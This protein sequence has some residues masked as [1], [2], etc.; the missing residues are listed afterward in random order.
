MG[1][2]VDA[3]KPSACSVAH[4]VN[5]RAGGPG[6]WAA[7]WAVSFL[8]LA[9]LAA[10]GS[11]GGLSTDGTGG[12]TGGSD[13]GGATCGAVAACGGAV[14]GTWTITD[15][16]V[17]VSGDLSNVCAGATA[18]IAGLFSGTLT[19]NA[20]LT[21]T[22]T[23]SQGGTVHYHF[24]TTCFPTQTCSQVQSAVVAANASAG[25]G[26]TFQSVSC[27]AETGGCACD[28]IIA[29][30]PANETGTYVAS[31]GTLTTTHDGT[32]DDAQYCVNGNTMHQM[33]PASQ[34]ATGAIILTK[35]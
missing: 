35:Q 6:R 11:S 13:G 25:M 3:G 4:S 20:N 5:R 14:V 15:Q 24:P 28:A 10:C 23:G 7:L 34:Q 2:V 21:Y 29:N 18:S 19:F 26:L 16:C 9:S 22:Q 31:G 8:G 1:E 17:I 30:S 32:A 33:A 27:A 12:T